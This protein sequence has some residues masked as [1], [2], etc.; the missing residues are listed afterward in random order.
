M[1]DFPNVSQTHAHSRLFLVFQHFLILNLTL[2]TD[3]ATYRSTGNNIKTHL[4]TNKIDKQGGTCPHLVGGADEEREGHGVLAPTG[5]QL[6]RQIRD[7]VPEA[8]P[9]VDDPLREKLALPPLVVTRA[10]PTGGGRMKVW[11]T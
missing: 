1:L 3:T 11:H 7:A 4:A 10:P 2:I 5:A 8:P 6:L 9:L